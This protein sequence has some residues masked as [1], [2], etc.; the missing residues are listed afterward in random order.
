MNNQDNQKVPYSKQSK[1]DSLSEHLRF[2]DTFFFLWEARFIAKAKA[3]KYQ[4]SS[5]VK[6]QVLLEGK[7]TKGIASLC[8]SLLSY[9]VTVERF[10]ARMLHSLLIFNELHTRLH[11]LKLFLMSTINFILHVTFYRIFSVHR[12]NGSKM[13]LYAK[14]SFVVSL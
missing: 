5:P 11:C 4:L 13:R 1:Q 2:A 6:P 9:A 14:L 12:K 3:T 8:F 7:V 10:L